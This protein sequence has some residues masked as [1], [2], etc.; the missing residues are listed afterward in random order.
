LA[1]DSWLAANVYFELAL[2]SVFIYPVTLAH[3]ATY[4][5]PPAP[6]F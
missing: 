5:L 3:P 6:L 2:F 1:G 4:K